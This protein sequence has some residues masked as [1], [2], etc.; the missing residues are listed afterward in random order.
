MAEPDDLFEKSKM[1]FG[2]HLEDLRGALIKSLLAIAIGFG[3]GMLRATWFVNVVKQ[4]LQEAV[5]AHVL[6]DSKQRYLKELQEKKDSG[7]AVP[8]DMEKAVE[9][10]VEEGLAPRIMFVEPE[11]LNLESDKDLVPLTLWEPVKD[12][13][14]QIIGTGV[15]Q[16]FM[17]WV[18]AAL[19][20]GLVAASPFVFYFIWVFVAAGLYPHERHYVY[21]FGPFSVVLFLAGAAL[22]FWGAI[23]YVLK[24]LF[25]FYDALDI[26]PYPVINDWM[27]FIMILPLG[28]GV[29]FQLPLVMLFLERIGVFTIENYLKQWRIAVVVICVISTVLTPADPQS[30]IMMAVP[31]VGLYFGGVMLCRFM[32]RRKAPFGTMVDQ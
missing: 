30:M 19:V 23:P 11:S 25:M 1:T 20:L 12:D 4:P 9:R 16:G 15:T 32:P 28:F 6:K 10:R 31:L 22:A 14:R 7:E 21:V 29:S 8:E 3:F 18:K 13:P 24:F 5:D 26:A 27:S 2:E 17:V